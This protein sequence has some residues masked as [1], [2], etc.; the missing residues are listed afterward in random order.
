MRS[1]KI[2]LLP[3][4]AV[5]CLGI[6]NRA[7]AEAPTS[8][9]AE[10]EAAAASGLRQ[11]IE[12]FR[13]QEIE[14]AEE[15]L[16]TARASRPE[17]AEIA[18]YLG[19][20][21]LAQG[22]A[23][24]AVEA[25][26]QAMALDPTVSAYPFWL[27][28]ALV[29]RIEEAPFIFKLGLAKRLRAA[30]EQAVEIDPEHLEARVSL[31]RYHSEAPAIAGGSS[32]EAARQLAEIRRR[33]PALAR[34]AEGLI[35]EQLGRPEEAAHAFGTAVEIDPESILSWRELGFFHQRM[36][37][38]DDARRAF[39]EV[40]A[41]SPKDPVALYETAHTAIVLSERSAPHAAAVPE[42]YLQR[43]AA[44][45]EAY[46]QLGPGPDPVLL[47][48]GEPPRRATARERLKRIH[49]RLGKTG[50]GEAGAER[51]Y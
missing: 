10:N 18:Y 5:A 20:V 40:L 1:L 34:V 33:D 42:A 30:Y 21:H 38:W 23:K 9:I 13:T 47:S 35:H 45:L 43:A 14:A 12:H 6:A 28:E 36:D 17:D 50:A 3:G 51:S 37:H 32:A 49:E 19:R 4:L 31:A 11:A 2:V 29:E 8:R 41:R 24:A 46:L 26:E 22:R 25:L 39:E 7:A 15:L 27:A 44:T 16:L 48:A